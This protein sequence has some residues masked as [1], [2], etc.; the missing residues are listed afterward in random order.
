MDKK[1]ININIDK[2]IDAPIIIDK[3]FDINYV[4]DQNKNALIESMIS[5]LK[6]IK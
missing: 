5:L 1:V 4:K 6:N 3:N 2:L